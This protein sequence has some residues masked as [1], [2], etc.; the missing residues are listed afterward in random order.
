MLDLQLPS[1]EAIQDELA[2]R[3]FTL[4]AAR[5]FHILNKFGRDQLLELNPVQLAIDAAEDELLRTRNEARIYVL[6]GRQGGI[7]T[8]QQAKAL[9]TVTT[10]S[11]VTALTLAHDR[12]ATDKIFTKITRYAIDNFPD[13]KLPTMGERQTR[14]L[15]FPDLTSVFYTGTAGAR[16]TG[17]GLTLRRLHG[18]EF[19][20]WDDPKS[21]LNS[22]TGALVPE[23]S[24]VVLET[25]ASGFDSEAHKFWRLARDGGNSYRALFFPWWDC[26]AKNYRRQLRA[27]TE[28][29]K[30]E[31]DEKLLIRRYKLSLQ[32]I[33]WRR[34]KIADMGRDEFFQE[35]PE[36]DESCWLAAGGL[37]FPLELLKQ[38]QMSAP[39]PAS[40]D[41]AGELEIY[42]EPKGER[43][44][45]GADTAEGVN[46]DRST[47]VARAFPSWRLLRSYAS[48][49]VQPKEFA[50]ILNQVGRELGGAYL[51][52]EKNMHGITVLRHLRD[53]LKYPIGQIYHRESLDQDKPD[54]SKR[55]G[56]ATTAESVP[57]MLGAGRELLKAA[58][59]GNA[60]APP[61]AAVRDAFAVRRGDN[62]KFN[63]SGKDVLVAEM[64]AWIGRAAPNHL[65]MF[66]F[67]KAEA[68]RLAAAK[69]K[70][71]A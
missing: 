30:L 35:Y 34:D 59:A 49:L 21:T 41:L 39:T 8:A 38:L 4:W 37:Y 71:S 18:S 7:T 51:V 57:I 50:G 12:D 24:V 19:A 40:T 27:P 26:D 69:G 15:E 52:V 2:R 56:W 33:A 22:V 6:K 65:G 14:E 31:D 63:L 48:P 1:R 13:G 43:V 17:R 46:Q 29:G 5:R 45:I 64:L 58:I 60:G 42:D 23:R 54:V 36:D 10:V 67:L 25:T 61:A 16:K 62:G 55:I 70:G 47:F 28:L 32:Q 3:S 11:G 68:E 53:D 9:H 66:E 44:I 20:F